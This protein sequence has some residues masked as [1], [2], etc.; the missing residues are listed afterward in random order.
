MHVIALGK[1]ATHDE[2]WPVIGIDEDECTY[3]DQSVG[4]AEFVAG[5]EMDRYEGFWWSPD[6]RALLVQSTDEE[7]EPVW[8]ISDPA[9][10]EKP[11]AAH[12]YARALTKNAIVS[13]AYVDFVVRE[14]ENTDAEI[15]AEA[16]VKAAPSDTTTANDTVT[17]EGTADTAD[18]T[19]TDGLAAGDTTGTNTEYSDNY[20]GNDNNYVA[21]RVQ[22]CNVADIEWDHEAYEYL[23]AVSWNKGHEPLLLVQDRLQHHDQVLEVQLTHAGFHAGVDTEA[24]IGEPVTT[25]VLEEHTNPQWLD[26]IHGTPV[27]T[28]DGRLVCAINDMEN[29]TNRLTI[30]GHPFTPIGWQIRTVLDVTDDNVLAVASR[31]PELA[32]EVPNEWHL[33]EYCNNK[34]DATKTVTEC[35]ALADLHNACSADVVI[36][37]YDGTV[38]PVTTTPGV[39]TASRAGRGIVISGRDMSGPDARMYHQY[40]TA[41]KVSPHNIQNLSDSNTV[42]GNTSCNTSSDNDVDGVNSTDGTDRTNVST[43]CSCV[44]TAIDSHAS[45]PGFTPNTVFATL[46]S[47]HQLLAAITAPSASSPYAQAT[48]LPVLLKPYGGPGAQQALFSQSYYWESQWWADQGFLVVTIDGRGT[49][50]RGPRWEREI[51]ETM[52]DITLADQVEAVRAL[53]KLWNADTNTA[54]VRWAQKE[55]DK[56]KPVVTYGNLAKTT[57]QPQVELEAGTP[58]ES[59]TEPAIRQRA[60]PA[61]DLNKVAMIGWS[62][63][64]FLS[65]LAVLD[66]PDVVH[67]ACAGA[68][69]T[70]W[71][72]YD[73][74]YTERYLGLDPEVYR[75]NSIIDDAPKLNRPLML[76]HGFADDNVTIAHSLR[77]SQALMAAGRQHTFLPLTGITHMTNDETVAQNLLTLQRDFLYNALK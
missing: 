16:E 64:G 26:L 51:Y 59:E 54:I 29:D 1:D 37:R 52:K 73:T 67:A 63:G 19:D 56:L 39:W 25:R 55:K 71:T 69:P 11:A 38:T 41:P 75:R 5:E 12:R 10:P 33:G 48:T 72:L 21:P 22:V 32:T 28:P 4:L 50:G 53:P 65:A 9:D 14:D 47:E 57:T 40:N 76:I 24:A 17:V 15:E 42:P 60:L 68:P 3:P 18:T 43:C 62:Y 49:P 13:L 31:T 27:F 8:Y 6:S 45:K 30:D 35:D 23:A 20:T 2:D 77:L 34:D 70:D 74:H 7:P 36:I 46:P 61:P 44:N 66:A 58:T